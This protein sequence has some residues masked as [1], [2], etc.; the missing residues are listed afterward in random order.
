LFCGCETGILLLAGGTFCVVRPGPFF[1]YLADRR[2]KGFTAIL[3]QAIH[4]YGDYPDGQAH[5]NEGGDAFLD[6]DPTRLNPT[7]F[8]VLDKRMQALSDL[9][10]VTAVPAMWWGKTKQCTPMVQPPDRHFLHSRDA[11]CRR[12]AA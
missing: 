6:R 7:Y 2:D 11:H 8:Q 3:M 5:R 12:H 4:G 10:F 9:G 1:Q